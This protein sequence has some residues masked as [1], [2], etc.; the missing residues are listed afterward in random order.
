MSELAL[1]LTLMACEAA[2]AAVVLL[3]LFRARRVIG[4]ASLYTTVGVF[5]YLAT[6]LA[7]TTFV[8]VAP[9]FLISPG[10]VALFPASLF[11]VML[12]YIR[13]DA[14]EAR[15]MIYGLLAAN[16]SASL[17]GVLVGLHLSSPL[18][19]KAIPLPPELFVFSPRLF[20]VGTLALFADTV[21]IILAYEAVSRVV[22]PLFFRIWLSLALVLAFDTLL[23]V[24][25]GFIEHP[26]YRE[27]LLSGVVGKVV[28]AVVYAAVLTLYLPRAVAN[29]PQT[30]DRSRPGLGDLFQV[31]TYRQKY[32]ALQAQATRD[33]LTGIHNRGF[34]DD[35]L[36]AQLADSRRRAT[37]LTLMMVDVDNFKRINDSHGHAEGDR[38]LRV[39]A[40][41]LVRVARASDIACR[42]G[43]EE[44]CV[45]LPGTPLE[46]AAQ[47][48]ARIR[49]E[50]P[51]ACAREDIAG[52]T[53]ITVTIGIAVCPD[54]G[55]ES[56]ALMRV[57]DQR[58][59]RGK[60]EGRDR[61]VTGGTGQ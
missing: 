11:A 25:G 38:A 55:T 51:A 56:D 12:V 24:T 41:A 14:R 50:V 5:Y 28:A 31:L 10:S 47:L 52:R 45:I 20:I 4:L 23:F 43:G 15:S 59:Y 22:R 19:V 34:F 35:T 32:E 3:A 37:P 36:C 29:D 60:E 27:I 58:L 48:A 42:Y 9:G 26:A 39:I 17:L 18:A 44:F 7:A 33:P 30:V 40:R 2:F 46:S 61:V 8:K 1:Q 21:L 16:V 54:D 53:R 57:A 49:Q 13:E 6:L